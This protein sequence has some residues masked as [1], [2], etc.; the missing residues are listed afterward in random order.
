MS[1]A[2]D[3]AELRRWKQARTQVPSFTP[4][5]W[6]RF[7]WYADTCPCDLPPGECREH[8]RARQLQ[9]LPDGDWRVWCYMGGEERGR[10]E[11]PSAGSWFALDGGSVGM[12]WRSVARLKISGTSS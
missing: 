2:S 10:P 7:D 5:E 1:L 12:V 4:E 6:A 11:R 9:R 8:A 3:I